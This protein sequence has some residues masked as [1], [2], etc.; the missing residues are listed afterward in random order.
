LLTDRDRLLAA[1]DRDNRADDELRANNATRD[2]DAHNDDARVTVMTDCT[3]HHGWDGVDRFSRYGIPAFA[4]AN[5]YFRRAVSGSRAWSRVPN[6]GHVFLIRCLAMSRSK[7]NLEWIR[8]ILGDLNDHPA[9]AV[10][11]SDTNACG[12]AAAPVDPQSE[13]GEVLQP[14]LKTNP[15]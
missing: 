10:D 7:P 1:T 5:K 15:E 9:R 13:S 11:S 8:T 2:G 12:L 3:R 14:D 4:S 6:Q